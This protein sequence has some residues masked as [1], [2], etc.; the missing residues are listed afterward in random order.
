MDDETKNIL[1]E[2]K[3]CRSPFRVSKAFN[4]DVQQIWDLIEAHQA[5][6]QYPP[7]RYGGFGRP[8]LRSY[9]V[10]RRRSRG[11]RWDNDSPEIKEA[12]E[13]YEAGTVELATGRDGDWVLL[14]AI[15]R[16]RTKPRPGCWEVESIV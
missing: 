6:L 14:Y 3:K 4:L 1:D 9:L 13:M 15:P 8:E 2:Y 10:A 11:S 12:R 5:Y 16:K 7:E